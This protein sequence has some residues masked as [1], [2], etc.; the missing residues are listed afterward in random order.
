MPAIFFG[1]EKGWTRS[2]VR[3]PDIKGKNIISPV[4]TKPAEVWPCEVKIAQI[5]KKQKQNICWKQIRSFSTT[6]ESCD[7][8]RR[9]LLE[10]WKYG[11]LES[12][13]RDPSA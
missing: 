5:S 4:L 12:E 6:I 10:I 1:G 11:R 9:A 2:V 8:T 13:G 3:L 7:N